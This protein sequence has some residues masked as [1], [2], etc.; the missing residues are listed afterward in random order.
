[1]NK[2]YDPKKLKRNAVVIL[3]LSPRYSGITFAL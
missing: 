2:Y 3:K 1:M